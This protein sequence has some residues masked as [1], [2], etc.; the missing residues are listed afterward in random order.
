MPRRLVRHQCRGRHSP[1][2]GTGPRPHHRDHPGRLR[3]ALSVQAVQSASSCARRAF[4]C[5]LGSSASRASAFPT[6]EL[7]PFAR[8]SAS[9]TIMLQSCKYPRPPADKPLSGIDRLACRALTRSARGRRRRLLFSADAE[10]RRPRRI[11]RRPYSRRGVLRHRS[12]ER[13]FHR[14]AA[15]AARNDAIRRRRRPPRHRRRRY[16][17]GL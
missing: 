14:A 8:V 12:R 4:R 16:G 6:N 3:H 1:R 5:R 7:R 13:P 15:H 17:G 2:Q 9:R 11:S 10:A